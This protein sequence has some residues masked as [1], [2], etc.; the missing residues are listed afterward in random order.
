MSPWYIWNIPPW[1]V[2]KSD[3]IDALR[4][5]MYE[6]LLSV[7]RWIGNILAAL[8]A[9]GRLNHALIVFTS[10]NGFLL[11]EHR[12]TG[13]IVPYEESIRV[14]WSVRWDSA[15]F[16]EVGLTDQHLMLNTDFAPSFAHVAGTSMGPTDGRD[17]VSVLEYRASTP[18]RT[19]FLIEHGGIEKNNVAAGVTYCGVRT[20]NHTYAQYWNGFEE[21]YQLSSDRYQLQNVATDPRQWNT[22][23]R[24]RHRARVLC[25]PPPPGFIWHH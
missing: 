18:W 8:Q 3:Q 13:K 4:E 6:S 7:D 14:P 21:L 9:T 1:T 19:D 16:P 23:V 24:L 15:N 12:W 20:G 17:F 2:S 22:L 5:S 11:G 25:D 10:D